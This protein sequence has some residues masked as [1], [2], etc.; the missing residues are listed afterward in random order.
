VRLHQ[1]WSDAFLNSH[2]DTFISLDTNGRWPEFDSFDGI[3]D[4]HLIHDNAIG[5]KDNRKSR[6]KKLPETI[7]PQVKRY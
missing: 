3:L 5:T 4:L 6:D 1:A 7:D 2:N